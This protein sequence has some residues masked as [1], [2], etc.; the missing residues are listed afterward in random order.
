MNTKLH[1]QKGSTLVEMALVLILF[2]MVIFAVMEFSIAIVRSAQLTEATRGGLRYAITNDPVKGIKLPTKSAA[3]LG[4]K[5]SAN[6]IPRTNDP[7]EP[8]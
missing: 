3:D 2:L 5:A 1:R 8:F 4:Q 6:N 7:F